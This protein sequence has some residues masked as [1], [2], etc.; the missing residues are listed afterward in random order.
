MAEP[1]PDHRIRQRCFEWLAEQSEIHGEVLPRDLLARGFDC[2]G[3]QIRLVGPQGIFKPRALRLP[4]SITTAPAGPYEDSVSG[5]LL[6]YKYRGTDPTHRDNEGLRHAMVER[7]PL[8]YF[9]GVVKG[10]YVRFMDQRAME[11]ANTAS[12]NQTSK[13]AGSDAWPAAIQAAPNAVQPMPTLPHPG[14]AVKAEARSMVE[15]I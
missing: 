5:D 11:R 4:L 9:H 2:D 1:S 10:K 14:T 8:V 12:A 7:V 3:E 6:L 15:R 13:N